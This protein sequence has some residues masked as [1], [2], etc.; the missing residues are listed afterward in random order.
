M[1]ANNLLDGSVYKYL[2]RGANKLYFKLS[3][4]EFPLEN[5]QPRKIDRTE[6]SEVR[7]LCDAELAKIFKKNNFLFGS[8]MRENLSVIAE[9][10]LKE[11][12]D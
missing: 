5:L 10:K 7:I 6:D 8:W 4:Y 11:K 12:K 1:T 2:D 9:R 3:G